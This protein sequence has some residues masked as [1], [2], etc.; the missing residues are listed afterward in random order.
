VR[1]WT[2]APG[3]VEPALVFAIMREESGYRA[4]VVSPSGARGLL[5]IMIPTGTRLA[6]RM[7]HPGFSADDLFDPS[8]NIKLGAHYLG[9]LKSRFEGRL[10]ASIASYN[11][12]PEAVARWL[13]PDAPQEDD[14]WV[15]SIPYDQTRGYVRRVMRSLHAYKVLY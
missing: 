12:G 1:D 15:E 13:G 9:E 3:S 14:V 11:A 7:G 10:S 5:Q 2:R 4:H 8:T 6:A